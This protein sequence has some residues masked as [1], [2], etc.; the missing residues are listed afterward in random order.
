MG[1]AAHSYKN[2]NMHECISER[3]APYKYQPLRHKHKTAANK[4][5]S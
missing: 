3:K 4:Q 1:P 5:K 2:H